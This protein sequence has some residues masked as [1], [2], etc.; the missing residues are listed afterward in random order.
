MNGM[1]LMNKEEEIAVKYLLE[2]NY[3][4]LNCNWRFK[5]TGIDIIAQ[6]DNFPLFNEVKTIK[7]NFFVNPKEAIDENKQNLLINAAEE[8]VISHDIKYESWFDII[9][10][11]LN[12]NTNPKI[13]HIKEAF[14]PYLM[15]M[16]LPFKK[17]S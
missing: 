14:I 9:S 2:Y 5:H 13:E 11:I 12:N 17:F 15:V 4:I 3:E 1:S 16:E 10:I 7:N 6:T 8:Y